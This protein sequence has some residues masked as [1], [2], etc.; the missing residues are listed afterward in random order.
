[1]TGFTLLVH[2]AALAI[3]RLGPGEAVPAWAWSGPLSAVVRTPVELSVVCPSSAVPAGVTVEGPW[4]ALEVA[5]PLSFALTGVIHAL[6]A[7]LAA[8]GISLF[9]VSTFDTDYLLVRAS[10]LE[11][12]CAALCDEGH[13][14]R[15]APSRAAAG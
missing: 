7:P 15:P 12:A 6:S 10:D 3:A 2:D 13:A 5:G 1:M 4:R 11:A 14:V 9:V 8:A